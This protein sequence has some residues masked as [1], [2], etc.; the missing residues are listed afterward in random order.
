MCDISA[1]RNRADLPARAAEF[2]ALVEAEV[3]VPV[4]IVGTGPARDA[5]LEWQ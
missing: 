3:G 1:V 4:R 5:V 2:V